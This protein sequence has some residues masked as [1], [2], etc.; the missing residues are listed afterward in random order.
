MFVNV[1]V[2]LGTEPEL[3]V[4]SEGPSCASKGCVWVR[5]AGT[6]S[7][8]SIGCALS[9]DDV[10]FP[11]RVEKTPRGTD[12]LVLV[13][14]VNCGGSALEFAVP[15]PCCS[16]FGGGAEVG[17]GEEPEIGRKSGIVGFGLYSL[18]VNAWQGRY[19]TPSGLLDVGCS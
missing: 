12:C 9:V 14:G 18:Q 5:I 3:A 19:A 8:D 6:A 1:V 4:R 15:G 16:W 11:K 10:L 2:A 13:A 17:E 7:S